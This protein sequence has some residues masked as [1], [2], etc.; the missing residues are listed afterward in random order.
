LVRNRLRLRFSPL[1][2]SVEPAS[3]AV[4]A[5]NVRIAAICTL[6]SP[7]PVSKPLLQSI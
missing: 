5:A 2:G 4:L 1:D 6:L 7:V 3:L